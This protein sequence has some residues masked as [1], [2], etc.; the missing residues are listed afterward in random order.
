M[1]KIN[2]ENIELAP[3]FDVFISA[4]EQWNSTEDKLGNVTNIGVRELVKD[5]L[6]RYNM[7]LRDGH[8]ILEEIDDEYETIQKIKKNK[9]KPV[10]ARTTHRKKDNHRIPRPDKE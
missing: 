7:R 1:K 6:S 10:E 8:S 9:N 3:K 4:Y 2:D 5:S